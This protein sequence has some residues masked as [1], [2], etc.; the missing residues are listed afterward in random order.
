MKM[1]DIELLC[2]PDG[3][4]RLDGGT[5]FGI[6]PKSL[7][8]KIDPADKRNRIL[9]ALNPLLIRTESQNI[10]VDAGLGQAPRSGFD[11]LYDLDC[12]KL[13]DSLKVAGT[14]P[15]SINVVIFTHLHFDH[16][17][18]AVVLSDNGSYRTAFPNARYV[19]QKGEWEDARSTT[20]T[21]RGSYLQDQLDA[22][23][24]SGQLEFVEGDC[25][26]FPH[27]KLAV[28][29][30]HTRCHQIVLVEDGGHTC[31]FW[32]DL[33]PMTSHVNMPY[34]MS[35]D[36]YPVDTLEQKRLWLEKTLAGDWINYFEH[37]P[38]IS[39]GRLVRAGKRINTEPL[40]GS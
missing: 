17:G 14:D 1:G 24:D 38:R 25:Q 39:F 5:M 3:T 19:V 10:L 33:I 35:Y 23:E 30:G 29:G 31:I 12:G 26:L 32:G 11:D 18:G 27:I 9:I 8:A 40:D 4:F 21:T 20:E 2:V 34:I 37:D 6:V 36:L 22:I 7:W 28:T 13:C 16:C 15:A